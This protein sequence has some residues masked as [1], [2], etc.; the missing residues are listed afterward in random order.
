MYK[1]V[2]TC[3]ITS[4]YA[5]C[6]YDKATEPYDNQANHASGIQSREYARPLFQIFHLCIYH[7]VLHLVS[8]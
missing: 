4:I 5:I 6:I 2:C 8:F 3:I 7:L 1:Y